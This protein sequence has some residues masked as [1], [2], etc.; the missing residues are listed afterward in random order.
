VGNIERFRVLI[1]EDDKDSAITLAA[2]LHAVGHTVEVVLTATDAILRLH[3]FAP[4]IVLLDIAMPVINGYELARAIRAE[5]GFQSIPLVVLSGCGDDAHKLQSVA[6]GISHHLVKPV[7]FE[8]LQRV[9]AVELA[10]PLLSRL[11]R[12]IRGG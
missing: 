11:A 10:G 4:H 1:V 12:R 7:P 6:E 2:L 5:P 8:E 9:L 3:T